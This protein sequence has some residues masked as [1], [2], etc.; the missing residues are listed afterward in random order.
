MAVRPKAFGR[1][2]YSLKEQ[3]ERVQERIKERKAK[4]KHAQLDLIKARKQKK[5]VTPIQAEIEH[6][7]QQIETLSRRHKEIKKK[8]TK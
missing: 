7:N 5:A 1:R 3:S 6:H 2:R 4:I 8:I